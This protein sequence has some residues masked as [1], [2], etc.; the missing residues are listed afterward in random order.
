MNGIPRPLVRVQQWV[1]VLAVTTGLLLRQPW[2]TTLLWAVLLAGLLGGTGANL[3]HLLARAALGRERLAAAEREDAAQQRFNQAIAA[4]LLSGAQAAFWA[5]SPVWGW[6]LAG[7]VAL[8]AGVALSGFC[9]GCFLYL[10]LRLLRHRLQK[11]V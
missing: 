8:A 3:I 6:A 10:Q 11:T 2:L 9:L 5:G 7:A 1:I 4:V